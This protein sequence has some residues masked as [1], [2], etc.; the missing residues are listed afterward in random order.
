MQA[1]HDLHER[2]ALAGRLFTLFARTGDES[3]LDESIAFA[4]EAGSLASPELGCPS[5]VYTTLAAALAARALRTGDVQLLNEAAFFGRET[6]LRTPAAHPDR[7]RALLDYAVPL[8][9]RYELAA[10]EASLEEALELERGALALTAPGHA[11]RPAA[12]AALSVSLGLHFARIG[13][14]HLLDEAIVLGREALR[15]IETP[16]ER[17]RVQVGLGAL[18]YS[19]YTRHR[20]EQLAE[21]SERMLLTALESLDLGSPL[22]WRVHA[23]L[24]KLLLDD[25]YSRYDLVH[26]VGHL[27]HMITTSAAPTLVLPEAAALLASIQQAAVPTEARPRILEAYSKAID[28]SSQVVDLTAYGF[29]PNS[30]TVYYLNISANLGLGAFLLSIHL[31]QYNAGL[32][33]LEQARNMAWFPVMRQKDPQIQELPPEIE[34]EYEDLLYILS[35]GH[36]LYKLEPQDF[37]KLMRNVSTHLTP[38]DTLHH[39]HSRLKQLSHD[40]RLLPG[41]SDFGCDLS[42]HALLDT[43]T[44]Y[45]VVVL[46]PAADV[47]HALLIHKG[48]IAHIS[49]PDINDHELKSMT[50]AVDLP[51]LRGSDVP[52]NQRLGIRV[53][54]R[55]TKTRFHRVLARLWK[56][57]VEPIISYLRLNVCAFMHIGPCLMIAFTE[58]GRKGA[59]A[60][61]LV[62]N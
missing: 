58:S 49:L 32:R 28:L 34:A 57:V 43:A 46:A 31:G 12:C 5:L 55:T 24:A 36:H 56:T 6:L 16:Y 7:W 45:P 22:R 8:K 33:L 44:H 35:K 21:E 53:S 15:G 50:L 13:E 3:S 26:A 52:D 38:R 60:H 1:D 20:Q 37:D 25:S 42:A 10:G 54:R 41:H 9:I 4:R 51:E 11:G 59:S 47:C 19:A 48:S 40:I 30:E 23:A 29:I 27:T 17:A 62:S 18:L 14:V 61:L 2:I 39:R